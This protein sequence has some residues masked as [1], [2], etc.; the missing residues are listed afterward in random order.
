LAETNFKTISE[1]KNELK[2][3]FIGTIIKIGE[4]KSGTKNGKDWTK[5]IFTV[6]DA[7]ASVELVC[8]G[9]TEIE[10][11]KQGYKYEFVN[12]WWKVYE[13]NVSVQLGKYGEAKVIGSSNTEDTKPQPPQQSK[14]TKREPTTVDELGMTKI[15][16][17]T[18]LLQKIHNTVQSTLGEGATEAD[19]SSI[20]LFTKLIYE[21]FFGGTND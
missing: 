18:L 2:G 13:E 21:K 17:E 19:R 7:T 5:K 10:K 4:L 20:D 1:A 3:S 14:E 15:K 9:T 11:F 12:P 8:W 16:N 6:E